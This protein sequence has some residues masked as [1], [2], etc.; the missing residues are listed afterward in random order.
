MKK[1]SCESEVK[2]RRLKKQLLKSARSQKYWGLL[3]PIPLIT[4]IIIS[5]MFNTLIWR[6][7]GLKRTPDKPFEDELIN[8]F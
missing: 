5:L 2:N 6:A 8:Q 1:C 4:A 7:L 3:F